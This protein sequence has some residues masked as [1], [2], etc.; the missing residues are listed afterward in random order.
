MIYIK[1]YNIKKSKI[2]KVL[3]K[4]KKI[5]FIIIIKLII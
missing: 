2:I 1:K 4:M 3:D 5:H